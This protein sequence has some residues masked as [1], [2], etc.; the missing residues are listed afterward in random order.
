MS[1]AI[2]YPPAAHVLANVPARDLLLKKPFQVWSVEPRATVFTAIELMA[3]ARVGAVLVIEKQKLVGILSERDYARKVIL[4]GRSS[5]DTLV[6]EIMSH[7]VIT[8]QPDASIQDCMQLMTANR[9]RHLPV[10]E[11]DAV[12]GVVSI[13]DVVREMLA[14]QSHALDELH[15]YVSGEPRLS[16][17]RLA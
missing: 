15:R 8:I 9:V 14:Q 16:P 17:G 4:I 7:P 1:P 11:D 12:L 13:G 2:A 3:R 5:R 6:E 10:L